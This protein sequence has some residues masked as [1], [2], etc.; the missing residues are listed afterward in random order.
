MKCEETSL[1]N[2]SKIRDNR[3][4]EMF[5]RFRE[6]SHQD[7]SGGRINEPESVKSALKHTQSYDAACCST[8]MDDNR[9]IK[10]NQF[11]FV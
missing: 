4:D 5:Q 2:M 6:S 10:S 8:L 7:V 3:D 9:T 11:L 1:N